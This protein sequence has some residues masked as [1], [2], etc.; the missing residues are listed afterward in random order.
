MTLKQFQNAILDSGFKSV[1]SASK[2]MS[3]GKEIK[4]FWYVL[5]ELLN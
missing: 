2:F 4:I 3:A 1:I 5:E